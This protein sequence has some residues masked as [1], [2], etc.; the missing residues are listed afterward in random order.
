MLRSLGSIGQWIQNHKCGKVLGGS[1]AKVLQ[2]V[3]V[4]FVSAESQL[5]TSFV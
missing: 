4:F 1:I 5:G 2:D 3:K